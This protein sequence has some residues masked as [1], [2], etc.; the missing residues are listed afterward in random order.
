MGEAS[1]NSRIKASPIRGHSNLGHVMERNSP[2]RFDVPSAKVH[3]REGSEPALIAGYTNVVFKRVDALVI[4]G[5]TGMAE[6]SHNISG[7]VGSVVKDGLT[8]AV[9]K[10]YRVESRPR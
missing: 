4:G 10:A 5:V 9:Q 7:R 6:F 3:T 8:E 1:R 2:C